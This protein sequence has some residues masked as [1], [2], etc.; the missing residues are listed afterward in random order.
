M[1]IQGLVAAG[2]NIHPNCEGLPTR[3]CFCDADP[4]E[5]SIESP[6]QA[7]KLHTLTIVD[8]HIILSMKHLEGKVVDQRR[9]GKVAPS[10]RGL[11]RR[12]SSGSLWISGSSML[13]KATMHPRLISVDAFLGVVEDGRR[14]C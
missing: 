1:Y 5:T 10:L 11:L 13:R 14:I 6:P 7:E 8:P 2:L 9:G 12:R 4:P 3:C